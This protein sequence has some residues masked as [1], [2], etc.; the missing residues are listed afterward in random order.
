MMQFNKE[1]RWFQKYYPFPLSNPY[2]VP[3]DMNKV[4][5][6]MQEQQE[7]YCKTETMYKGMQ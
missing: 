5:E 6:T 3:V 4:E 2:Y 1:E 7:K